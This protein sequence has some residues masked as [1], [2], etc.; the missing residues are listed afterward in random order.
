[1]QSDSSSAHWA[2]DRPRQSSLS[3]EIKHRTDGCAVPVRSPLGETR[4]VGPTPFQN[5]QD[6]GRLTPQRFQ[7]FSSSEAFDASTFFNN[8]APHKTLLFLTICTAPWTSAM[9]SRVLS[10]DSC[11]SAKPGAVLLTC[12]NSWKRAQKSRYR[13]NGSAEIPRKPIRKLRY[14]GH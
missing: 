3:L 13:L 2:T 11:F 5:L 10:W 12:F 9:A 7:V 6:Q 14:S 8:A 1:M 4:R